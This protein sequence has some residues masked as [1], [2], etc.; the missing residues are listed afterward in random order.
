MTI[1]LPELDVEDLSFPSP[2]EAL[3]EPNGLLAFGGDLR[4][5]RLISAYKHGVFPWFG[6]NEPLLW[7][8]PSP[9][10]VFEPQIYK[11]SKSLKKFQRKHQYR[12]TINHRTQAVIGYCSSTRPLEETWL[13]ADMR[14]AYIQL[15]KMGYCHSVEVWRDDELIGGLYGLS[16]GQVFCGE[17]MFSLAPNASKIALW[18]FCHHFTQSGGKLIDCQVMNP[19]LES[20][21]AIEMS[22]DDFLSRLQQHQQSALELSCF[23]PQTLSLAIDGGENR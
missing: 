8:S 23:S 15:A 11:P 19:H 7:W 13:N 18:Y 20:L 14:A 22:R 6:P 4:P 17:S 3:E 16:I 5:E 2:Y 12:V 9:R 21:G 10:A 1:Y